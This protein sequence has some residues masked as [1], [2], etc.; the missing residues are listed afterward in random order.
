MPTHAEER[1]LPFTQQQLF[2]LVSFAML[3]AAPQIEPLNEVTT[4]GLIHFDFEVPCEG[5][6]HVWG[7]V[8]DLHHGSGF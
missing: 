6:Y 5:E 8:W 4:E 7:L 3:T 2:D 1:Q